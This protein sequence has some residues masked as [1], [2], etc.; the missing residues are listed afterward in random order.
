MDILVDRNPES[1]TFTLPDG[2]CIEITMLK[3]IGEDIVVNN[4]V[5][6]AFL[7]LRDDLNYLKNQIKR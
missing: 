6:D 5:K 3:V 2:I 7:I 4:S 1:V